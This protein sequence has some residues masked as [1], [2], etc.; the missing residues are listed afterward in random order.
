MIHTTVDNIKSINS[1]IKLRAFNILRY[2]LT[3][4]ENNY[5]Q[6]VSFK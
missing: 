1:H 3:S 6:F 2:I 4:L 5:I